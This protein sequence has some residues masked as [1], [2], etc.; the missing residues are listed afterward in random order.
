MEPRQARP[1]NRRSPMSKL[2]LDSSAVTALAER[3][4]RTAD[5]LA[6]LKRRC[7]WPPV[8]PSAVLWNAC[9]DFNIP[10]PRQPFHQVLRSRRGAAR[11]FCLI[12]PL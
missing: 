9:R 12:N 3:S 5:R 2:V 6:F 10:T 4:E 7:E 11:V 1:T 8:V